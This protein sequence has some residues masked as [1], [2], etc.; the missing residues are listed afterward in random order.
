[1]PTTDITHPPLRKFGRVSNLKLGKPGPG[2]PR[3]VE[4][5]TEP[6]FIAKPLAQRRK[7]IEERWQLAAYLGVNKSLS[8]LRSISKK[9]G[10]IAQI[11]TSAAI[12]KDKAFPADTADFLVKIPSKLLETMQ[13]AIAIRPVD[14]GS[15]TPVVDNHIQNVGNVI[16]TQVNS[17]SESVHS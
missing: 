12:A 4:R 16:E 11:V 6:T 8:A 9:P 2:R 17:N 7:E 13:I 1:M 5:V 14:T 3:A 10:E 15:R